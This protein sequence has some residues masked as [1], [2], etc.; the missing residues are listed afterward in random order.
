[1][2]SDRLEVRL[3]P[4]HREKLDEI[5]RKRGEPV[6]ALVREMIDVMHDAIWREERMAAVQ[7]MMDT[8]IEDVPG[9]DGD[10]CRELDEARGRYPDLY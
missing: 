2:I 4:Q 10:L 8:T 1:V 7:R 3:D 6:A 9:P 5:V